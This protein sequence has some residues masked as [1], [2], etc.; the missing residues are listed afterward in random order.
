MKKYLTRLFISNNAVGGE[1][2]PMA[3]DVSWD[4]FVQGCISAC[5]DALLVS[6]MDC[7]NRFQLRRICDVACIG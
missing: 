6:L 7:V 2:G 3:L 5:G 1:C 4:F